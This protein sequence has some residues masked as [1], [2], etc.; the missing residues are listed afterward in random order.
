MK[1][2][3]TCF[4]FLFIN[5]FFVLPVNANELEATKEAASKLQTTCEEVCTEAPD[6]AVWDKSLALGF[7]LTDGNSKHAAN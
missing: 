4:L 2:F 6:P 1:N 3:N 7:N 5:L